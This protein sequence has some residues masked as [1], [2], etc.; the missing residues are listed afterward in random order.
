MPYIQT[1]AVQVKNLE[2][3]RDYSNLPISTSQRST[4]TKAKR[5]NNI[6]FGAEGPRYPPIPITIELSLV[7]HPSLSSNKQNL[8]ISPSS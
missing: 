4:A 8:A 6:T 1:E 7:D 2:V 3:L 5:E